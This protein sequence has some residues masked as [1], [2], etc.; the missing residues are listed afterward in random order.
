[1][2]A[3]A[4]VGGQAVGETAEGS[5]RHYVLRHRVGMGREPAS[6]LLTL[7]NIRAAGSVLAEKASCRNLRQ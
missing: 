6:N 4:A 7:S 1:V 5:D 3:V 2:L